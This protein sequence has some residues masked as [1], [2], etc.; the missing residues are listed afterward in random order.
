[1][2]RV[3]LVR[4]GES[5]HHVRG[6]TG[7]WTDLPLTKL[8]QEQA[9]RTAERVRELVADGG[10]A[11]FTSDLLRA[12]MTAAPI[13][14]VLGVALNPVPELREF[15]NGVASGLSLSAAKAIELPLAGDPIDWQPYPEAETWRTMTARV[16]SAMERIAPQV[17]EVAI[18]VG[19]GNSGIAVVRWWLGLAD[20]GNHRIS[21]DLDCCSIT[22]LYENAW[23]ERTIRRLND[24]AHLQSSS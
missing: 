20:P 23:G 3:L 11:V 15:N 6:M 16:T 12:L 4:H 17:P 21:F 8:G 9:I 1:M 14:Q 2:R 7:G 5:E 10:A 18:I 19:H 13:C 24:I 22:D